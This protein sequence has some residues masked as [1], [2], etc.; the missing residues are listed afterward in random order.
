MQVPFSDQKCENMPGKRVPVCCILHQ[1]HPPSSG[2]EFTSLLGSQL[3]LSSLKLDNIG[4]LDLACMCIFIC[5]AGSDLHNC[6]TRSCKVRGYIMKLSEGWTRHNNTAHRKS[7]PHIRQQHMAA[8]LSLGEKREKLKDTDRFSQ[9]TCVL[10]YWLG[11]AL[12]RNMLPVR[13][14]DRKEEWAMVD[15]PSL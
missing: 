15:F 1:I 8:P 11:L 3:P 13:R 9:L 6:D 5:K 2:F 7:L 12:Y 14:P 10:M 4:N